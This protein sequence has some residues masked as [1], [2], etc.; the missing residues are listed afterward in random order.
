VRSVPLVRAL[1]WM[2]GKIL[3]AKAE[4]IVWSQ[5]FVREMMRMGWGTLAEDRSR[6]F[7]AGAVC[8]PWLADTVF[9]PIPHGQFAAYSEP[10]QVKILWT[11]EAERLDEARGRFATETRTVS[12]DAQG[13]VKFNSYWHRFGAGVVVI[14]WLFLAAIRRTAERQ[15]RTVQAG[16]IDRKPPG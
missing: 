2:R 10:G 13:R 9:T 11:L 3:G 16:G 15:W 5:G 7:V 14:R 1:F 12:T 4:G 8:R 6:W